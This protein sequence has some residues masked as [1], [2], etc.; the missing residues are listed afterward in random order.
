MIVSPGLVLLG[1]FL[2]AGLRAQQA[3]AGAEIASIAADQSVRA[4][5]D[6]VLALESASHDDLIMLT[7]IPAPPFAEEVRAARFAEMLREAG[8]DSVYLDEVGNV[9]ALRR[10]TGGGARRTVVIEGHLDTVFPEG[11]DV[12]VRMR[13]DT[14]LAPGIGDDT[15]GL[16]VVLTVLRAMERA[17]VQTE[18]DVLFVGTVGEEGLG[19]LRGVKHFFREGGPRIDSWIAV[20]G[21]GFER[22]LHRGLGSHRYRVTFRGP[23]GHSWGAF[24]LGNPTHAMGRAMQ[25]FDDRAREF[26]ADG[27]RTSYNV[28]RIGGGT[29]VNSIPFEAWMEVDMRSESP[30][31]LNAIDSIF[32]QAMQEA[33]AIANRNRLH[34]DSLVADVELIGDRPSGILDPESPIVQRAMAATEFLGG[35][36][37]LSIGS[38]NA[39]TP[40]ALGVPAVT[41]GRGGAGGGAHALDEWWLNE[42]GH[43]AIQKALLLLV[44][45]AGLADLTP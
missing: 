12:T 19:D 25:V 34:G 31:R 43:L 33:E 23:G 15:R 3:D 29:S 16:I 9:I 38:T 5:M 30:E 13:G 8:A 21:G 35:E 10:G 20:D 28:G 26:V 4:A 18:G 11:T 36:P 41:I 14:L 24:G 22:V 37:S 17:G 40:I 2:S 45:E 7:E 44:A 6:A 32:Q 42:N 27:P 1:L 39:N